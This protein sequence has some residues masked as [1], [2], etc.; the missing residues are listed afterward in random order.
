MATAQSKTSP[1]Q[2][3]KHVIA[4]CSAKGGVGKSTVAVNLAAALAASRFKV[5][6]LDADIYGPS[7]IYLNKTDKRPQVE[8]DTIL[9]VEV[10][11]IQA[12]SMA[13]LKDSSE[14]LVWRAPMATQIIH[15]FIHNVKWGALD[16][17]I[18]DLPPGTGDVQLTLAQQA[19][20]DGAIIITTPQTLATGVAEKG[21]KMFR[22][23]N[24]PVLGIVE[25]MSQLICEHCGNP[26]DVFH[27]GGGE[28]LAKRQAV[29]LLCQIPI[30][31]KLTEASEQGVP[32]L[33]AYPD[34]V[35]ALAFTYLAKRL[36]DRVETSAGSDDEPIDYHLTP[37][38]ALHI[39]WKDQIQKISPYSLRT[40]C[41]C[42]SCVDE[43]SGKPRLDPN[44]VPLDIQV[45]GLTKVGRYAF[46]IHFSDGHTTGIYPFKRLKALDASVSQPPEIEL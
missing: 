23:L 36:C 34:S 25:N 17:L 39:H 1:L 7:F 20:I 37:E 44:S 16:F 12:M 38:G 3:I 29:E 19:S 5:G 2:D 40:K 28:D 31:K 4:V 45:T 8:G 42:A 26:N 43:M 30:D 6:L 13:M 10:N 32:V 14:P 21:L 33:M 9:P 22:Q 27:S 15:Q 35:S 46:G 18:I 24:I 41:R 11:G